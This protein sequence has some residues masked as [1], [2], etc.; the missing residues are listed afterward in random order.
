MRPLFWHNEIPWIIFSGS[1]DSKLRVWNALSGTCIHII[2]E[3]HADIYVIEASNMRPNLFV[4]CSRDISI[5][6]W[7]MT[8]LED[9]VEL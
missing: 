2:H 7:D 8:I 1:W 3:H 9:K 4:T 6:F 5:R